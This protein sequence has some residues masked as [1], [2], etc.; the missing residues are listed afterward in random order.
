MAPNLSALSTSRQ[1][2]VVL[3]LQVPEVPVCWNYPTHPIHFLRMRISNT[4]ASCPTPVVFIIM[5]LSTAWFRFN[6][7]LSSLVCLWSPLILRALRATM[8][9]TQ[10]RYVQLFFMDGTL[11]NDLANV[12]APRWLSLRLCSHRE[13]LHNLCGPF[14]YRHS[15]V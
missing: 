7:P 6:R 11:I 4:I 5:R 13:C 2:V 15:S 9:R 3:A 8:A 12:T 14:Q 10:V 1:G